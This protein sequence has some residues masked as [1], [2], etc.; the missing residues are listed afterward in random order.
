MSFD[1][2]TI[3]GLI[4]AA[5]VAAILILLCKLKGCDKPVC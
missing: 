1:N 5:V 4:F 2:L 3:A